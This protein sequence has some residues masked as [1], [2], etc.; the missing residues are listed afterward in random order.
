MTCGT[1][2]S[3]DPTLHQYAEDGVVLPS[4]TGIRKGVGLL[5]AKGFSRGS[6]NFGTE[7]NEAT[8]LI[9]L[10]T[11]KAKLWHP[12]QMAGYCSAAQKEYGRTAV[13][14]DGNC[15][16]REEEYREERGLRF[17]KGALDFINSELAAGAM[18]RGSLV[19]RPTLRP[20]KKTN[21]PVF[22]LGCL[23]VVSLRSRSG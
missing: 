14:I 10:K 2:I 15:V 18:I 23:S 1:R 17:F 22:V 8:T 7:V 6:A 19:R 21:H 20:G 11:R 12:L 16:F 4:V 13:Y 3:I 9:D 5:A